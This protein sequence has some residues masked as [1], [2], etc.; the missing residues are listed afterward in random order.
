VADLPIVSL[1]ERNIKRAGWTRKE[2]RLR[3][4]VEWGFATDWGGEHGLR[5]NRV[6]IRTDHVE[7]QHAQAPT[8]LHLRSSQTTLRVCPMPCRTEWHWE[9]L[10]L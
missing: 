5:K 8:V 4:V 6:G 7:S 9:T 1:G 2:P 3:E 10:D